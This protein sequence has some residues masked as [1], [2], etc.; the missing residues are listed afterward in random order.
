MVVEHFTPEDTAEIYRR[1]RSGGRM[2]PDGLRYLD[3]WVR[4]DLCGCFQLMECDDPVLF[5]EWIAS[6]GN[7][8]EAEIL[9][10]APSRTTADLMAR[11]GVDTY[12]TD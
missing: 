6:W 10:V 7:L 9:P 4:A 11:L 12:A 2:L 8:V 5:Q 3:S 1:V